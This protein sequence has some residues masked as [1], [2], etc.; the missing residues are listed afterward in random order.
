[1]LLFC[2]ILLMAVSSS[3]SVSFS[4]MKTLFQVPTGSISASQLFRNS[5]AY[6]PDIADNSNVPDTLLVNGMHKQWNV[7]KLRG[8]RKTALVVSVAW[9]PNAGYTAST[10][11]ITV[12]GQSYGNGTYVASAS[13]IYDAGVPA[14][15]ALNNDASSWW[16][17]LA[18]YS[19]TGSHTYTGTT[20]T[21]DKNNTTF[22][23]EWLQVQLPQAITA[24]SYV[25]TPQWAGAYP[26]TSSVNQ[27]ASWVMLG[28]TTGANSS[29]T[30][31]HNGNSASWTQS[32]QTFTITGNSTA[33]TYYRIVCTNLVSNTS[34][35]IAILKIMGA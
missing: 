4:S 16:A 20:T 29:W 13:S 10:N 17:S 8:A 14:Y 6:V 3:G 21:T 35:A 18:R 5:N 27:P 11:T 30:L 26:G 7:S 33:Y 19:S 12:S 28:S 31:L 22:S 23:G 9:P 15:K 32:S 2:S 34:F 24:T 25:I 1:M